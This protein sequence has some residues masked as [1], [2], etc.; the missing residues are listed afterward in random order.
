LLFSPVKELRTDKNK[1]LLQEAN[2]N[3]NGKNILDLGLRRWRDLF[4]AYVEEKKY[5]LRVQLG[6]AKET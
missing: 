4:R 1:K 3:L 6:T 5:F 2:R